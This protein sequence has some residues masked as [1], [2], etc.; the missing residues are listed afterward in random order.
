MKKVIAVPAGRWARE[1][2]TLAGAERIEYFLD[3]DPEIQKNGFSTGTSVKPVY[4]VNHAAAE[5]PDDIVIV[6]TD[7]RA[8]AELRDRLTSFGLEENRHFFD[9]WHLDIGFYRTI[10]D[11]FTTWMQYENSVGGFDYSEFDRR[12][13]KM[14]SLIPPDVTSVMDMGCGDEVLKRHLNPKIKYYGLDV[15]RRSADTIIC[16]AN[17]EP[18]PDIQVDAYYMAGFLLY[19]N[20]VEKLI[21]QMRGAKY[22]IFD[23]WNYVEFRRYDNIYMNIYTRRARSVSWNAREQFLSL[24]EMINALTANGFVI[25]KAMELNRTGSYCCYRAGNLRTAR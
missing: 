9:G 8:F 4:P 13:G 21:S 12:A 17:A 5:N 16:D 11:G 22:L 1:L 10:G 6:I 20:D 19:M 14:A 25:E 2:L 15:V 23:L 24:P 18:L 7:S 3:D